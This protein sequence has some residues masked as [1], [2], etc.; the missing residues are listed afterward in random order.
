M[1]VYYSWLRWSTSNRTKERSMRVV[2]II[3]SPNRNGNTATLVRN[4][5]R[6]AEEQGSET[7]E[8]FL[9]DHEIGFCQGCFA[10]MAR[11]SCILSDDFDLLRSKLAAADGIVFGS[12]NYAFSPNAMMKRFLER[13]GMLEYLTSSVVGGKHVVAV[14]TAGGQGARKVTAYLTGVAKNGVFQRAYVTGQ[15]TTAAG[16]IPA[17][18][19]KAVVDRAL[20]MGMKLA[21]DIA[22]GHTYPLQNMITR[23]INRLVVRPRLTSL[24]RAQANGRMKAVYEHLLSRKLIPTARQG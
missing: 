3:S 15:V 21:Q 18:E 24:I 6:G 2:G 13:L 16:R 1:E 14:S 12:P 19:N 22:S 7:E 11:G 5:L 10:C 20:K 9:A 17:A 4:V 8:I 23:L